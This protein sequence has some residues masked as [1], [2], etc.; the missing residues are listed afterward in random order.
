MKVFYENRE[1][2]DY[3]IH[4][5]PWMELFPA[6]SLLDSAERRVTDLP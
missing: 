6:A 3:V 1:W 2:E 4:T 5:I